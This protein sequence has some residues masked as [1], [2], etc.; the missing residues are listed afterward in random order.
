MF[1]ALLS[2]V[3][4]IGLSAAALAQEN[5]RPPKTGDS[6]PIQVE[7]DLLLAEWTDAPA[8]ASTADLS[9]PSEKVAERVAALEKAGKLTISQRFRLTTVEGVNATAQVGESKPTVTGVARGNF[10]GA[11]GGGGAEGFTTSSISYRSIGTVVMVNP[12]VFSGDVVVLA[13]TIERSGT[14]QRESSP[15]VGESPSGEKI[16]AESNTTM[17]LRTSARL[18]SGSTN[19]LAGIADGNE[20]Q[21]VLV[22]VKVVR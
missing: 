4:L 3:V 2:I 20:R 11:R 9:G 10:G 12:D 6:I 8:E 7:V 21:V 1:R 15:A 18:A 22:T 14:A 17:Q 19:L 5:V 13:M 16:K